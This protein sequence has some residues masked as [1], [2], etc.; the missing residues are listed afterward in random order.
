[1]EGLGT[2][3]NE[4]KV[5][6]REQKHD[7]KINMKFQNKNEK[8]QN[9]DLNNVSRMPSPIRCLQLF[10]HKKRKEIEGQK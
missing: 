4:E 8:V 9:A 3:Q 5:T 1:M 6:W 7:A 2:G 10:K